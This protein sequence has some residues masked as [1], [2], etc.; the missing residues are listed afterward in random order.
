MAQS[1][2]TSGVDVHVDLAGRRVRAGLEQELREAVREGRLAP[3][4]RL[5]SSRTLAAELGLGRNTVADAYGQ[6]VAEG[7]L[8]ARHGAGTWVAERVAAEP[9][10][11]DPHDDARVRFDLRP[12][13]PDLGAFPRSAWLAAAR[14]ALAVAA[15]DTLGYGDPRGLRVLREAL[16]EYL[17]RARRV[18]CDPARIVVCAGFA[19]GLEL[20]CAVLRD[21]GAAAVAIEAHGHRL[22]RAIVEHSGL[23]TRSVAVDREG[24]V[25]GDLGDAAAAL[26]TPAHQFPLGVA[27]APARRR[28]AV[29]WAADTG[30]LLIEDDYDG[31]FRYDRQAV[32]AM[33]SLA[34]GQVVYAGTAAKSL[35]PGV[36]LGWLV[37][38]ASL[39]EE[40]VEAKRVRSP[41]PSTLEQLTLAELLASGGL[42]PPGAPRPARLPA[43]PRSA[44]RGPRRSGRGERDRGRPPRPRPSPAGP[45]GARGDRARR[46]PRPRAAGPARVHAAGVRA[47]PGAR[48]RLRATARA[49]LQRD[50]R[51][52]Q[53]RAVIAS[54]RPSSSSHASSPS[55]P[56]ATCRPGTVACASGAATIASAAGRPPSAGGSKLSKSLTPRR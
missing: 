21:R 33:Q 11:A 26:L 8:V 55:P 29:A 17:V 52:A 51:P 16:A 22:H 25:V 44:P 45:R 12:G 27:L 3:G 10:T 35:A 15:D 14:R 18:A 34:P 49:R 2:A 1:R 53:R 47:G 23:E 39:V 6:L 31:E 38:P 7:W 4:A 19:H 37:L 48:A 32:G 46:D 41:L 42:R 5:P 9:P 28:Q 30:A 50:R 20:L 13:V 36:R 56:S 24:A 54:T 43:P 40:V